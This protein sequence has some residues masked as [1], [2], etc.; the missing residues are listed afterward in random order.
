V[1]A[2]TNLENTLRP[3]LFATPHDCQSTEENVSSIWQTLVWHFQQ[4]SNGFLIFQKLQDLSI[5]GSNLSSNSPLCVRH[6]Q[7]LLE[8]LLPG[9]AGYG[10]GRC[11]VHSTQYIV[12]GVQILDQ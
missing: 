8:R 6:F 3:K 2:A 12:F 5:I 7:D 11:L 4:G 1:K 10:E 9:F